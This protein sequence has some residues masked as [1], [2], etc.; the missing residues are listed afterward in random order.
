MS[1][2]YASCLVKQLLSSDYSGM[3]GSQL[4]H[5]ISCAPRKYASMC[6]L[7]SLV[8]SVFP[9]CF[10]YSS[11]PGGTDEIFSRVMLLCREHRKNL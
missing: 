5:S 3:S 7:F 1:I 8:I 10:V 6:D 9:V 2:R 11:H 4:Q